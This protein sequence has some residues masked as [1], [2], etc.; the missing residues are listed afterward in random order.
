[1]SS[2]PHFS[3]FV[4]GVPHVKTPLA[5]R[6]LW[7]KPMRGACSSW[8]SDREQNAAAVGWFCCWIFK[9]HIWDDPKKC[10]VLPWV[11]NGTYPLEIYLGTLWW[12]NILPWKITMLLMG[13]STISMAI[14]NC[15]LLVHQRVNY[16]DLTVLPSPGNNG[17]EGESSPF[18]AWIN[19][20]EREI[21]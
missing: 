3:G 18:M 6:S 1:M 19:S 8:S 13:K 17:W 5:V 16:N 11:W 2:K 4:P 7:M 9:R 14:F 21:L 15:K 20:G 10:W 12:T